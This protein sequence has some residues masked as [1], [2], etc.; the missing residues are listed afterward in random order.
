MIPEPDQSR[1]YDPKWGDR[2]LGL[3]L[4]LGSLVGFGLVYLVWLVG[5]LTPPAPRGL[6]PGLMPMLNP[7]ACLVPAGALGC[8]A[9]FAIGL[10]RL[11]FPE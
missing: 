4:M 5:P 10:R 11:L 1:R 3:L 6:P 2:L 9:L 7:I 8:C